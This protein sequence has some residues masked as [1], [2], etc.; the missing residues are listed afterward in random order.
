MGGNKHVGTV[1]LV[2]APSSRAIYK[3][4]RCQND[5]NVMVAKFPR[6]PV[7]LVYLAGV[8]ESAGFTPII[9]DCPA[10][11][12]NFKQYIDEVKNQEPEFVLVNTAKQ[13][14][15]EDLLA[16]RI[17]KDRGS[18]TVAFGY[19]ASIDKRDLVERHSFV[20]HVVIGEPELTI[21]A[22][23]DG[24][25][26]DKIPGLISKIG[27]NQVVENPE[28]PFN[29]NLDAL[30][31]GRHDLVA[32]D[33]YRN[34]LTGNPFAVIQASRGC[35]YNCRFCLSARMN[36]TRIRSRS[37]EGILSE[38]TWVV[39]NTKIREFFF[40][41]DTFT[42]RTSWLMRFCKEMVKQGM[43]IEW[44]TN[45]RIDTL[46]AGILHAMAVAGCKVLSIGVESCIPSHQVLLGKNLR[47]DKIKNV[48]HSVKAAGIFSVVYFLMGTPFDTEETM[49]ANIAFSKEIDA[50][51]VEFTPF[52]DF[53][54]I[55]LHG[56][57]TRKLLPD[58]IVTRYCKM[59]KMAFYFRPSKILEII[60]I[61]LRILLSHPRNVLT[62]V[63]TLATYGMRVLLT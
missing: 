29:E 38:V 44:Y 9:L 41:A 14:K 63:K 11:G 39:Q 53:G 5:A 19:L 34:P 25:P 62:H 59:G 3:E 22:L 55:D 46:D 60:S 37:V 33:S 24:D 1:F 40:R 15:K 61:Y 30:P 21:F 42:A 48:L 47:I 26:L 54:G 31:M 23:L 51:F 10:T 52:I 43:D 28:R 58:A 49:M 27:G 57:E 18:R 17:A 35:P 2:N 7:S 13:T 45:A 4:D 36:G 20:D 8:V 16:L 56:V 50:T 12:I 6:P 32:M